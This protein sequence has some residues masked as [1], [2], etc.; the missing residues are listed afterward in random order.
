MHDLT[1]AVEELEWIYPHDT[2]FVFPRPG[3]TITG[4]RYDGAPI[5]TKVI[6]LTQ[7]KKWDQ[8]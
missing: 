3:M 7:M 6:W 8:T 5:E 4:Q 1:E 2:R